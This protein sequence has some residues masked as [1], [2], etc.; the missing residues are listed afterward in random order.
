MPTTTLSTKGQIVIPKEIRQRHGWVPGSAI[1]LEELADGVVL[2]Q[3]RKVPNT[4]IDD[5]LGCVA[6]D[7]P[8]KTLEEMDQ[9]IAKGAREHK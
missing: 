8:A 7:G 1:E 6:Y 3:K 4:S 2:R 9:A 5:L